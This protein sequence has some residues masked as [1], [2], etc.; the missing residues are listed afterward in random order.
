MV[1]ELLFLYFHVNFLVLDQVVLAVFDA[2]LLLDQF[3]QPKEALAM[4]FGAKLCRKIPEMAVENSIKI[5]NQPIKNERQQYLLAP[6]VFLLHF[7][8]AFFN[9]L[10]NANQAL[11]GLVF[12]I[13]IQIFE[14]I[15]H[16]T[17]QFLAL[18]NKQKIYFRMHRCKRY[19]ITSLRGTIT[20]SA[21]SSL[22]GSSSSSI[23]I[24]SAA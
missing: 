1:I 5:K 4:E 2:Q 19:F 15:F 11:L 13:T 22:I 21:A 12:I 23:K 7:C 16:R 14:P 20:V 18:Q 10:P 8:Q 17:H 24:T 9:V 3:V 6:D